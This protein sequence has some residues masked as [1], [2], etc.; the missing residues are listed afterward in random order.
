MTR[1]L[2]AALL[3]TGAVT[4]FA[5]GGREPRESRQNGTEAEHETLTFV[6][7]PKGVHPYFEPVYRGFQDAAQKYGV[8]AEV[9]AP[10]RFDVLLQV[11]VIEDLIARGVDGI[12]ISADDDRGLVAVVHEATL[13]GIRV[14][15]VDAPAPSTE[16]LTYIGTDNASAGY[17]SGKRMAAAMGGQG[18]IAILQGGMA[19]T[20][21]NLRTQGFL[22]ALREDAPAITVVSVVDEKGDFAEAVNRTE[23]LLTQHPDLDAVFSVSAEGAPAAAAV[24]KLKGRAGEILVAGFDDLGDTLQG[25][26]DGS[27]AFC[28]VQNT[29]RMGW[30]SVE[31]LLDAVNGRPVPDFIDTGVVFVDRTNIDTYRGQMDGSNGDTR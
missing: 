4:A 20:N 26:R 5:L 6:M 13:A 10:P 9:E 2:A 22:R 31:R 1:T 8:L 30:L 7:V 16:A 14:I 23:D 27:I 11:K 24:V 17:Q 29:Y 28:V 3:L 25:I 12:A 19:A 18:T 15:T 21:L